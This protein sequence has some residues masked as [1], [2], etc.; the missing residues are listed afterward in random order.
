MQHRLLLPP[1]GQ[2]AH[3][4]LW[5]QKLWDA[6]FIAT[7]TMLLLKQQC[8]YYYLKHAAGT[9]LCMTE[10][11]I[12]YCVHNKYTL[13]KLTSD[14][15]LAFSLPVWVRQ[16]FDLVPSIWYSDHLYMP[17]QNCEKR[18]LASS[19]LFVRLFVHPST[20]MEQLGSYWKDFHEIW[21]QYFSK[22]CRE[23]S[24][25]INIWKE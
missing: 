24:S 3:Y 19:C 18:L 1:G 21:F 8:A 11:K 12:T 20:R 15:S 14:E 10:V 22:I 9:C 6:A 13:K 5:R 17:F 23:N 25:L 16:L 7:S 4:V 2:A